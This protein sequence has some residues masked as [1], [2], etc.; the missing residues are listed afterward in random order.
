MKLLKISNRHR[1]V[2][3]VAQDHM[4]CQWPAVIKKGRP[5]SRATRLLSNPSAGVEVLNA[6]AS[7]L[8]GAMVHPRVSSWEF[9]STREERK[10]HRDSLLAPTASCHCHK[11]SS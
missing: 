1:E 3:H 7:S 11:G 10:W 2:H 6:S 8:L 4:S 5:S 9:E